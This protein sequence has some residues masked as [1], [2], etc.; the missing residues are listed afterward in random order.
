MTETTV[1][2]NICNS[3]D[4][5]VI[6]PSGRAQVHRIVKCNVC[7]LIYA[8]PQTDNA[9]DVEKKY[10]QSNSDDLGMHSFNSKDNQYLQKQ[11]LQLKD[12]SKIIDFVERKEKGIFLEIGSYAG[13]FLNEAK[14]RGWNVIGIEPLEIPADF[15]EKEFGIKVIR[16]YFEEADI[17]KKSIEVVVACHVIEH[18]PNPTSFVRKAF[19]LLKL[20]GRLILETPT[21]D[22]LIFRIL[23][24][25][26]R[27]IRCDGHIYFFTK[28]TLI[29]LVENNGFKVLKYEKVG[30]TS[31][32]DRLFYNFDV[33]IGKK[34][35]FS[36]LSQRLK[37]SKFLIRL[38]TRDM[39]RIYCEKD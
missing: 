7:N 33:I 9:S 1:L 16:K 35:F 27:S 22:S 31:T 4:Y 10:L 25:R 21:Y 14:K 32:L 18:V 23:K 19:K 3:D 26:K 24:H 29:N 38:N 11:Y 20:G 13:I 39:L 37:L 15:S 12:Y 34:N 17:P 8:N 6:F 2:C 36:W 28:K 5:T 30:R